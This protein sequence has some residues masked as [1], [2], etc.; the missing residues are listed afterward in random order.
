MKG[1]SHTRPGVVAEKEPSAGFS[2]S[3]GLKK[4]KDLTLDP[5]G[6]AYGKASCVRRKKPVDAKTNAFMRR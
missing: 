3:E 5:R 6:K 2:E 1:V 4:P